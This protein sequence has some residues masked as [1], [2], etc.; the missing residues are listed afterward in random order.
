MPITT[1]VLIKYGIY[2]IGVNLYYKPEK[3]VEH[4]GNRLTYFYETELLGE[5]KTEKKLKFWLG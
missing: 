1:T 3:I 5:E 4:F 2:E